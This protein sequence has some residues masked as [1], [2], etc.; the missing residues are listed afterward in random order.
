MGGEV[1]EEALIYRYFGIAV[2]YSRERYAR[3]S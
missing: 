3:P 1:M 2:E